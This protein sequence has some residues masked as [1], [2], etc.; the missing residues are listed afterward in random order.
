VFQVEN[1]TQANNALPATANCNPS[2][3]CYFYGTLNN[4]V[5]LDGCDNTTTYEGIAGLCGSVKNLYFVLTLSDTV[6]PHITS[7]SP[8][9]G[10]IGTLVSITGSNFGSTQGTSTV[11][12]GTTAATVSTWSDT[13]IIAIAPSLSAGTYNVGV[14]TG[15]GSSNLV[16]FQIISSGP[17]ITISSESNRVWANGYEKTELT[18]SVLNAQGQATAGRNIHLSANPAGG[19]TLSPPS[20]NATTDISGQAHFTATSIKIG[21]VV[22]TATDVGNPTLV[23][24]AQVEFIQRRVVVFVQGI[25]AELNDTTNTADRH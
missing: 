3:Q 2:H 10:P 24:S 6:L 19:I 5:G 20:G 12:F 13:Q 17:S 25:I 16:S 14:T 18:V 9:S 22:F 11:T 7:I 1:T 4:V 15:P 21:S 8:T 23:A